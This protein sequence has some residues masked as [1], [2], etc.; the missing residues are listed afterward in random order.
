MVPQAA[1]GLYPGG[2]GLFVKQLIATTSGVF[3]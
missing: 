3:E 1:H 2:G